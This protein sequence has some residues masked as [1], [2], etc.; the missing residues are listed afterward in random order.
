MW[1][2]TSSGEVISPQTA[3]IPEEDRLFFVNFNG[4][5]VE[6]AKLDGADRRALIVYPQVAMLR[7]L[8]V[9]SIAR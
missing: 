7:G 5:T 1:N 8:A 6:V 4:S 2:D 9:D 3:V